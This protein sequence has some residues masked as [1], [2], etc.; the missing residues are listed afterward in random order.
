MKGIAPAIAV[1]NK[2]AIGVTPENDKG[3]DVGIAAIAKVEIILQQWTQEIFI[4][5]P[6]TRILLLHH[7]MPQLQSL[8]MRPRVCVLHSV[9]C[10][11]YPF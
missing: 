3:M 6:Y 10:L 2:N 5:I 9:P 11:I 1:D 4:I 7:A 8:S